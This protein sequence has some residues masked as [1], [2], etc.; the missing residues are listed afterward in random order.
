MQ[1]QEIQNQEVQD[2]HPRAD[3]LNT[4]IL[5]VVLFEPENAGNV[6]NIART[7]AV[8]GATLHLIRPFGFSLH[9]TQFRR[10][11]MDYL[12]EVTV[13]EHPD[14][15][16]FRSSLEEIP[17]RDIT[18]ETKKAR[19]YGFSS[20]VERS[21]W[22]VDYQMRDYLIFGPESRGLPQWIKDQLEPITLPMPAGGRS[23]NLAVSVGIGLYEALRQISVK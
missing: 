7:C 17:S 20:K 12:E 13:V 11:G 6:G 8:V 22:Q 16:S 18:R 15:M 19:L 23:L 2:Q 14:W 9:D 4:D 1:D 21:F 5:N 10:A 3:M